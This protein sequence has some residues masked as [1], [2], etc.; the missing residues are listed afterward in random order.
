MIRDR[1][2]CG[3][4]STKIQQRLL[5]K[6]ELSFGRALKIVCGMER[7]EKN[8]FDIEEG[9]SELRKMEELVNK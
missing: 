6:T 7:T 1:L 2:I 5:G 9:T 3:V 8:V 4:R